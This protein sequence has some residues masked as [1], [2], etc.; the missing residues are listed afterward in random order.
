MS[1][2]EGLPPARYIQG[3][4]GV[5]EIEFESDV[6]HAIYYA[7][8][9]VAGTGKERSGKQ[10]EALAW[11]QSL[12][13]SYGDILDKRKEILA[14]IRKI[15]NLPGSQER[16]PYVGILASYTGSDPN[17]KFG[18]SNEDDIPVEVEVVEVEQTQPD[19]PILIQIEA[20]FQPQEG[21]KFNAP[22]RVRIPR[23]KNTLRKKKVDKRTTAE[24]MGDA[25]TKNLLDPLVE[26]II[27]PPPPIPKKVRKKKQVLAT[28]KSSV[29]PSVSQNYDGGTD[30]YKA[31]T[32]EGFVGAKLKN[33]F[34]GAAKARKEFI[35]MGG[36]PEELKNRGFKDSFFAKSLAFEMGGDKLAR[37]KGFFSKD[38]DPTMDPALSR[39]Q[40]FR[41]GIS[42]LMSSSIPLQQPVT[43]ETPSPTPADAGVTFEPVS[44]STEQVENSFFVSSAGFEAAVKSDDEGKTT[45]ELIAKTIDETIALI[46]KKKKVKQEILKVKEQ[47]AALD[48]D[49]AQNIQA[50]KQESISD[51]NVDNSDINYGVSAKGGSI[52]GSFFDKIKD[53][54]FGDDDGDD[55]GD[56]GGGGVLG[57]I[58]GFGAE[59]LIDVGGD[60]LFDKLAKRGAAQAA[61]SGGATATATGTAAGG[62][63]VGGTAGGI[64]GVG[65][66]A[67]A[68]IIGGAGLA[69]SALGE[70]AFQLRKMG[71]DVE[72]KAL[73]NYEEKS[74]ADPRKSLDWIILQGM[75]FSNHTLN[76]LGTT[77]D[78]LGAPFRYAIELIRYPFL[79]EKD[80]ETQA[81]N[82]AKFDARVREQMRELLNIATFGLGFKEKGMFGNIY[83]D[84]KAQQE[85]M[86]KMSQ[87]GFVPDRFPVSEFKS[88]RKY[89]VAEATNKG[90]LVG[91]PQQIEAMADAVATMGGGF[92][93]PQ[94]LGV[95]R[96]ALKQSGIIGAAVRPYI[97]S[98]IAPAVKQFGVDEYEGQFSMGNPARAKQFDVSQFLG[99]GGDTMVVKGDNKTT[100]TNDNTPRSN[101]ISIVPGGNADRLLSDK[102]EAKKKEFL[103]KLEQI[104]L[105]HRFNPTDLFTIMYSESRFDPKASNRSTAK[106]LLQIQK[107]TAIDLNEFAR[108]N[109]MSERIRWRVM[110]T[111]DRI[112]QLKDIDA[113][114]TISRPYWEAAKKPWPET[115]DNP[116]QAYSA[117][118]APALTQE[119]DYY[120]EDPIDPD[121][122]PYA[123]NKALDVDGDKTIGQEDLTKWMK[124]KRQEAGIQSAGGAGGMGGLGSLHSDVPEVETNAPTTASQP[125]TPVTTQPAFPSKATISAVPEGSTSIPSYSM[126][127]I[128]MIPVLKSIADLQGQLFAT[129]VSAEQAKAPQFGFVSDVD[130]AGIFRHQMKI[131]RLENK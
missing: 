120:V 110:D 106:G 77:L 103:A 101:K 114:L 123:E 14:V 32:F 115:F 46:N 96:N 28:K 56:G 113:Y 89:M 9:P 125:T 69:A 80:K 16:Y 91:S 121:E 62:T 61:T 20:P 42:P 66:G 35:D 94:V 93:V 122:G 13:L 95:V 107:Q 12:G 78:I 50:A 49:I 19:E 1:F 6:D 58:L 47:Q 18:E 23:R 65:A 63:T 67:A 112:E 38:P 15:V 129:A 68:A 57:G 79:N 119:K 41:A 128:S 44:I 40:R 53:I 92:G 11:L 100:T 71:K 86:G 117:I 127:A 76:G 43:P 116:G 64:A 70:G 45:A 108:A 72:E 29:A 55:D 37:T 54:L 60:I 104:A 10:K 24:R 90:E 31:K 131:N 83:G 85:M 126:G 88:Q 52:F 111:F 3:Q 97:E 8:K 73:K 105:K 27:S 84:V 74:W 4:A 34:M 59:I 25:F 51:A 82:L 21:Q 2:N 26:S 87:G 81:K 124:Q 33:A 109:N 118:F 7:G 48:Y 5:W 102:G 130:M 39:G 17:I 36:S 99:K 75:K 98:Y 22:K 30:P